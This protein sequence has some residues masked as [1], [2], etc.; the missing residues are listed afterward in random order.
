M[1]RY[2][3]CR[4]KKTP[5]IPPLHLFLVS[6]SGVQP[7]D[8]PGSEQT[9]GPPPGLRKIRSHRWRKRISVP[10]S[11]VRRTASPGRR[12]A[13][14]SG[15]REM[16]GERGVRHTCKVSSP[17][18]TGAPCNAL[19]ED[20]EKGAPEAPCLWRRRQAARLPNR[21]TRRLKEHRTENATASG[22]EQT[23]SPRLL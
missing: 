6:R 13:G 19:S 7:R 20:D 17:M 5:S 23:G 10:P 21:K 1:P 18:R 2:S 22:P 11:A 15:M 8:A 14:A 4:N 9:E 3:R 16:R 12:T